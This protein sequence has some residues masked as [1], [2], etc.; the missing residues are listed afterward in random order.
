[1]CGVPSA[2]DQLVPL[3]A[4]CEP[5]LA[6]VGV[7]ERAARAAGTAVVIGKGSFGVNGRA[8]TVEQ[9]A[10]LVKLV[11][12]ADGGFVVGAQI[13]GPNAS[14][15]I[16]ELTVAVECALRAR[17]PARAPSTRIRHSARR[18]STPPGPRNGV[19]ASRRL[20]DKRSFVKSTTG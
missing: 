4:F 7:S 18:S 3:V 6:A 20:T 17:R 16:A 11:V 14:E 8:L 5:E 10:G 12:D 19:S 2:F 13:A 1:M 15:L 9:P